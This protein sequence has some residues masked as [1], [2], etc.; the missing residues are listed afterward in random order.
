MLFSLKQEAPAS[1]GGST[2]TAKIASSV[3]PDALRIYSMISGS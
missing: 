2:F 1:V 3:H